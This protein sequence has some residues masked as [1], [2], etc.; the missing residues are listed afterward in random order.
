MFI[1]EGCFIQLILDDDDDDD[2]DDDNDDD[3]DYYYYYYY[4]HYNNNDFISG[5]SMRWSF[6][7]HDIS[8]IKL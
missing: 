8:L 7:Y 5:T 1:Y 4:Y 2:D 6:A 3:D